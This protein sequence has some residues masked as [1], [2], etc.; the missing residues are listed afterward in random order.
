MTL[1][2]GLQPSSDRDDVVVVDV[3]GSFPFT[4]L[5]FFHPIYYCSPTMSGLI[6]YTL[7]SRA[8]TRSFVQAPR[9][10]RGVSQ[11]ERMQK[12]P[13]RRARRHVLGRVQV[14]RP[15]GEPRNHVDSA[16]GESR[17]LCTNS[18]Y[19]VSWYSFSFTRRAAAFI[20]RKIRGKF[21]LA[22]RIIVQ[23]VSFVRKAVGGP[24]KY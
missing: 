8:L 2:I 15:P 22:S 19:C 21:V 24:V 10:L 4:H 11:S 23:G 13:R 18:F 1:F 7:L 3:I 6:K 9:P 20:L 12:S 17:C 14:S 5:I 16:D